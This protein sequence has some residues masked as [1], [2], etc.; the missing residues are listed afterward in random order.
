M[1]MTMLGEVPVLV[2]VLVLA[3]SSKGR[4]GPG[5]RRCW[6][7]LARV[8]RVRENGGACFLKLRVERRRLEG[9]K[10]G[11]EGGVFLVVL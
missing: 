10:E 1:T 2:L 3:S 5:E 9:E 4:E 6:L 8:E 7:P 11:R